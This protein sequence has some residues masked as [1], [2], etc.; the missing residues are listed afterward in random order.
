VNP[1]NFGSILPNVKAGQSVVFAPGTY[2]GSFELFSGVNYCGQPANPA[3]VVIQASGFAL[4][5]PVGATISNVVIDGLTLDGGGIKV[6]AYSNVF[7]QNS[8]IQNAHNNLA[9]IFVPT[10]NGLTIARNRFINSDAINMWEIHN[11]VIADNSFSGCDEGMHLA[12]GVSTPS[13][14]VRIAR[15]TFVE[16]HRIMIELQNSDTGL[17]V[18]DNLIVFPL[19]GGYP[20]TYGMGISLATPG[21]T[22]P[23]VRNN[24]LFGPVGNYKT[25]GV[26]ALELAGVNVQVSGNVM[27]FWN[28]GTSIS[29][30]GPTMALTRNS[31]CDLIAFLTQDGGFNGWPT[32]LTANSCVKG[33]SGYAAPVP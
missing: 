29:Y 18:E 2:S 24:W 13:T 30:D 20:D 15:N 3:Q 32:V 21:A 1:G 31:Y 14:N 23:I 12:P 10:A 26:L 5:A 11:A 17:L 33:P 16:G 6:D 27:Q 22:G 4:W 28:S 8:V 9:G 25:L 7:I 19:N